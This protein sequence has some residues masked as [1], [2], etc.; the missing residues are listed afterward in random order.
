MSEVEKPQKKQGHGVASSIA[1]V[2]KSTTIS[3]DSS[4]VLAKVTLVALTVADRAIEHQQ[5]NS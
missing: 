2:M 4:R 3:L 5:S 1:V